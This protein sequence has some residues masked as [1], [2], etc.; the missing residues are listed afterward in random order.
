MNEDVIRE[1]VSLQEKG[2]YKAAI[3]IYQQLLETSPEDAQLNYLLGTA[4]YQN[5]HIPEALTHLTRAIQIQDN[6]PEAWFNL[7]VIY[8]QQQQIQE[9]LRHF[10]AAVER[11]GDY[12]KAE[13][14]TL[15]LIET[16]SSSPEP[17]SQALADFYRGNHAFRQNK[18]ETALKSYAQSITRDPSIPAA[19]CNLGNTLAALGDF[20]KALESY[21]RAMALSPE[22]AEFYTPQGTALQQMGD[23]KAAQEAYEKAIQLKPNDADAIWNFALLTLAQGNFSKGWPLHEWRWKSS[24]KPT[25]NWPPHLQWQGESLQGKKLFIHPEQGFGDVIQL[26]RYVPLLPPLGAEVTLG[27][28]PE[29]LR[30]M[31]DS[32][33]PQGIRVTSQRTD[34]HPFDL[35]CPIAS[36]PLA[37]RKTLETIP[38]NIPYLQTDK[39]RVS[40]WKTRLGKHTPRIGITWGGNPDF[41]GD[42]RRSLS[43]SKFCYA[44]PNGIQAI[45]LQKN[46]RARDQEQLAQLPSIEDVSDDL[47]DFAETAALI[48]TLDLVVTTCTS[49]AHLA[50]ALGKEVWILLQYA[51]DWRWMLNRNDSPWYTSAR[52]FRQETPG[53]WAPVLAKIRQELSE[54]YRL[55]TPKQSEILDHFNQGLALQRVGSLEAA[56]ACYDKSIRLKP[57]FSEAHFN[58]GAVLK[59]LQKPEAAIASY[60]EALDWKPDYPEAYYNRGNIHLELGQFEAAISDYD[61]AIQLKPTFAQAHANRGA[62]LEA[63]NA[64][65]PAMESYDQAIALE[66]HLADAW[67]NRGNILKALKKFDAAIESYDKAIHLEP[68]LAEAWTNRGVGLQQQQQWESSLDSFEKAIHLKPELAEAWVGQGNVFLALQQ[69]EAAIT[70]YN[71]AIQI[72]PDYAQAHVNKS[73]A[74]LLSGHFSQGWPLHE[75]RWKTGSTRHRH[76]TYPLWSGQKDL[77]GKTILLWHEQGFGDTLQFCRYLPQVAALGAKIILEAPKSLATLLSSLPGIHQL[78]L[79]DETLPGDIDFQCPLLSLPLALNV[80][81]GDICGDPYLKAPAPKDWM[82][83]LALHAHPTIGIVWRGN[84]D[85]ESD[86]RRSLSLSEFSQAIPESLQAICLQKEL[87]EDERDQLSQ[88]HHLKEVSAH[89]NDFSDTAAL[90]NQLNLVIT[91]CTSVAHLAGALGKEV[92]IL[93]QYSPDWRWMLNRNDSPWY[94]SAH[95]FRQETPGDWAPVLAKVRQSLGMRFKLPEKT[96]QS[97]EFE[98]AQALSLQEQG[99]FEAAVERYDTVIALR[100]E[101]SGAYF[102][103]GFSLHALKR[104]DAALDSYNKAITFNPDIPEAWSNRGLVLYSLG[105]LGSALES[106][107]Q[108]LA[109]RPDFAEAWFNRAHVLKALN[110]ADDAIDAYKSAIQINPSFIKAHHSLATALQAVGQLEAALDSYAKVLDLDPNHAEAWFN[111]GV[112]LKQMGNP[113]EAIVCY[114][115]AI[116]LKPDFAA[117]YANK[118]QDLLLRGDFSKGWP[119]YEWRRDVDQS[120]Y[121][122]TDYPQWSGEQSL[123]GKTILVSWE[124]GLGDTLQFC[125]YTRNLAA[126][127]ARVILESPEPLL[128]L[129][130]SLPYIDAVVP[131][132]DTLPSG[133]DLHCPIM[134][135]P[136]ALKTFSIEEIPAEVPYLFVDQKKIFAWEKRLGPKVKPRI[137]L[138]W[139][140]GDRPEQPLSWQRMN[141]QRNISF[142]LISTLNHP[143]FDF[144]S[145]QK[146]EPV[147]SDLPL[148][149]A[150]YWADGNFHILTDEIQD[151]EGTA[152]LIMALDLVISVDTAVVHLAGALGKPVWLLNRADTCWRWML[153]REDSPWYPSMKIF[154]QQQA[155]DWVTV[156]HKVRQSL[157]STMGPNRA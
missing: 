132:G 35:H 89:L 30:L 17:R 105:R 157:I 129:L 93:L 11:K 49:V 40:A 146:G 92:W 44:L 121:R 102:N 5:S 86:H 76:A 111:Q 61:R 15:A 39:N 46:I 77:S 57:D 78:L 53:D 152:G 85:F 150:R 43:L 72:K 90:I 29:L 83:D 112:V 117:A 10:D 24:M 139:N 125:R 84:P 127:G 52:L 70:R 100:P 98:Y 75:W 141:D 23:L 25:G 26:S 64:L 118:S 31:K 99:A 3:Q 104:F 110:N 145:L 143:H 54:R 149:K 50:G 12:P 123:S 62:A 55:P 19:H 8:L 120:L 107:D 155:H 56:I 148:L 80:E 126:L 156:L 153:G 109:L 36:L 71:Q 60:N 69:I 133:I 27:V 9:A 13:A 82:H 131:M 21:R 119:L 22:T 88:Q 51:P 134:S 136:L 20:P 87:S 32:F 113:E 91:T 128:S 33:E 115:R 7:G 81:L 37:F 4:Y 106:Y 67:S 2:R 94:T 140:G 122:H 14:K 103:R 101:A 58:R 108:A 28:Q 130:K 142:E 48:E 65:E 154:R 135:L 138:V 38:N 6:L 68:T 73:W 96:D 74:L 137:G 34:I 18:L 45:C 151:F 95:L 41:K 116:Q 79:T 16:L 147:E 66:P 42:Q 63:I 47:S 59:K 1:A 114:D 124:Q 144:F 97:A